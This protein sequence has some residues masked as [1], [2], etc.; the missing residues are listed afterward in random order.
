MAYSQPPLA[1]NAGMRTSARPRGA[2]LGRFLLGALARFAVMIHHLA[3][4]RRQRRAL[5]RL[6]SRL[7]DD[8]GLSRDQAEAE[9]RRPAWDAPRHW[10]R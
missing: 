4:I 3:G 2:E 7:L 9:A 1:G 10:R 8:V 6:D 5:Q